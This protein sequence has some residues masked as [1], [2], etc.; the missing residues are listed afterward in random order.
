[1][2]TQS[3]I[4]TVIIVK[5]QL[6]DARDISTEAGCHIWQENLAGDRRQENGEPGRRQE[7]TQITSRA[8]SGGTW[9]MHSILN[10]AFYI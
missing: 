5:R 4:F 7:K 1:M 8:T 6:S 3:P 9:C 2:I 10:M